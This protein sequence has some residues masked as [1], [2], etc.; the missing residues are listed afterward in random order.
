MAAVV[1][2]GEDAFP[3]GVFPAS[4]DAKARAHVGLRTIT[5]PD[6]DSSVFL[7]TVRN[8][9]R[10]TCS[11]GVVLG[12]FGERR[13]GWETVSVGKRKVHALAAHAVSSSLRWAMKKNKT[14][15]HNLRHT[16]RRE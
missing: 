16:L 6:V 14:D 4:V 15:Y 7:E 1:V 11:H 13:N 2:I 5:L 10:E 12:K 3:V 8:V 9:I